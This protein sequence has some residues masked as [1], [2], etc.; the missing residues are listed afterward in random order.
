M[1]LINFRRCR[2]AVCTEPEVPTREL[3]QRE[4][5]PKMEGKD[6]IILSYTKVERVSVL[7]E[8]CLLLTGLVESGER[9]YACLAQACRAIKFWELLMMNADESYSLCW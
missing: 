9:Q 7:D 4:L 1:A 5:F 6:M 8:P 2:E 3:V